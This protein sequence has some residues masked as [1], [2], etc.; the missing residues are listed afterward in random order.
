MQ[1]CF[2][3]LG[4]Y[5][6]AFKLSQGAGEAQVSPGKPPAASNIRMGERIREKVK[7]TE[8]RSRRAGLSSYTQQIGSD[9]WH[10]VW[11]TDAPI[12]SEP[13]AGTDPD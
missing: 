1:P 10:P 9:H 2:S 8:P 7:I 11:Y 13:W 12:T 5:V 6:G 3:D 4:G